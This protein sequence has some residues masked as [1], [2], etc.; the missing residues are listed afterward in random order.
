MYEVPTCCATCSGFVPHRTSVGK[1]QSDAVGEGALRRYAARNAAK[2]LKFL[3]SNYVI[4]SVVERG[5]GLVFA[6]NIDS[7]YGTMWARIRSIKPRPKRIW[8]TY[9]NPEAFATGKPPEYLREY[10][11]KAEQLN[12]DDYRRVFGIYP[13]IPKNRNKRRKSIAWIKGHFERTKKLRGYQVRFVELD[14]QAAEVLIDDVG[15]N[16]SF[17]CAR[18]S[19]AGWTTTDKNVMETMKDYFQQVW[20]R[21]TPVEELLGSSK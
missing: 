12:A 1:A 17:P 14:F 18:A 21:A 8:A 7:T 2:L 19:E 9:L 16:F 10:Y 13:D 5:T 4:D 3:L 15:V 6:T 20:D 11:Q